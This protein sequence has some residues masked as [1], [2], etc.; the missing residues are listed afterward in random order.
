VVECRRDRLG[1]RV[2]ESGRECDR[3][4]GAGAILW[5]GQLGDRI[6]SD[7]EGAAPP[8]RVMSARRRCSAGRGVL[9]LTARG[10]GRIFELPSRSRIRRSLVFPWLTLPCRIAHGLTAFVW[11]I[12]PRVADQGGHLCLRN[13]FGPVIVGYF[14]AGESLGV[15]TIR[16]TC[17]IWFSVVVINTS[18]G[19][20]NA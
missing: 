18:S 8:S 6:S 11:L 20:K 13:P 19:R 7:A 9:V 17:L 4:L 12:H 14:F 16:G 10:P 2:A 15:R 3:P 1:R 5:S